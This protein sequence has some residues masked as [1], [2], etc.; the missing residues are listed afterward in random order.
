MSFRERRRILSTGT[1]ALALLAL[2]LTG[3]N[4]GSEPKWEEDRGI[5]FSPDDKAVAYQHKGSIYVA[6]TRGDRHRQVYTAAEGKPVISSPRWAPD[7]RAVA[8]AVS[9]EEPDA[10]GRLPYT[11]W[12]WPAP[13]EI[14]QSVRERKQGDTATLPMRWS[15]A[16]PKE[17]VEAHALASVQIRGGAVF[18]WHPDGKRIVFLDADDAQRQS[19]RS[20]D[21]ETGATSRAS[22]VR[23]ASLAFS[24]SPDG[25]HLLCATEEPQA[26]RSGLWL[27][28]L[29]SGRDAW[30]RIESRPGPESVPRKRLEARR[31]GEE[32]RSL[33]DLRPRLGAWST[34]ST[35]LAHIRLPVRP[36]DVEED[37]EAAHSLVI[38]SVPPQG[39]PHV[40]ALRGGAV[41]HDLHWSKDGLRVGF[42]AGLELVVAD[43]T[44]GEAVRLGGVQ[45][46]EDFIGWSATG[47]VMAYLTPADRFPPA[48][49]VLPSGDWL[50]W[51]P[52]QRH[53]LVVAREDGTSPQSRFSGMQITAARWAHAR[54]KLSF[55]ATYLPTVTALPPGDPAAV[56][57]LEDDA[58]SWYPTDVHEYAQVGHYYLLNDRYREAEDFYGDALDRLGKG[59]D[60]EELAS[61]LHLWRGISRLQQGEESDAADDL[62][63]FR[64]H[65]RSLAEAEVQEAARAEREPADWASAPEIRAD[66]ILLSTLL[67]MNQVARAAREAERLAEDAELERSVQA[68][69]FLA[70]L[71]QATGDADRF[72]RRMVESVLPGVLA[73]E[74]AGAER[75]EQVVSGNLAIL[76]GEQ[77][78]A[79]VSAETGREALRALL[80]LSSSAR[81]SHPRA[82][83][84][85]ARRASTLARDYREVGSEV[86]ALRLLASIEATLEDDPP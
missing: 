68:Q 71:E 66:R 82:A 43:S 83:R 2:P 31:E 30:R 3:Q 77:M 41:P 5:P 78:L 1:V 15:P 36:E 42:L 38:S 34:R 63:A 48:R 62:S 24:I 28:P 64:A 18:E 47:D 45:T 84:V 20:V 27:G 49:I 58:L 70:L 46:V 39:E 72:A 7:Q 53:H 50:T 9:G 60:E 56:L 85:L 59:A 6:R 79:R 22:P 74:P 10:S 67:S 25:R 13:E 11:I 8:F 75:V 21:V 29:G 37:P 26:H 35:R 14:W 57:D 23:A 54:P 86:E 80:A 4:C 55:W 19:V 52:A 32:A 16:S 61:Q 51:Q 17:I 69:A 33:L 73:L 44:T 81:G 40:I 12:F 65:V 76:T